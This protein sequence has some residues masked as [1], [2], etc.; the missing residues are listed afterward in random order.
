VCSITGDAIDRIA[1]AIDQLA[2]DAQGESGETDP[3]ALAAR[4]ADVWSMISALD[5]ELARRRREY[6]APADE[7]PSS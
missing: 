6:T 1:D 3:A 7:A 4:I 5:P 2:S